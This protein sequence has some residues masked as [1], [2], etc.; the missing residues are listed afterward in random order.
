MVYNSRNRTHHFTYRLDLIKALIHTH[1]PQITSPAGSGR[2]SIIHPERLGKD[3]SYR[4]EAN[5]VNKVC[6][7]FISE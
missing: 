7:L 6:C 4:K 5:P 1:K 2:P 3:P